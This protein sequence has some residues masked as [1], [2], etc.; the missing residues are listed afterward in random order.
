MKRALLLT[1]ILTAACGS[2]P[3]P[4]APEPK[5][6]ARVAAPELRPPRETEEE[7]ESGEDAAAVLRR[8]YE[9]IERG[10]YAAAWAMRGGEDDEAARRRFADNFRAY[11]RYHAEI[12]TPS[13]PASADGYQYVEVP[14]MIT[15]AFRGGKSFGSTGSVTLRRATSA[16]GSGW[17]IYTGGG[18]KAGR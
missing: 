17:R 1:S 7:R 3:A 14:V 4:Q 16:D 5:R 9:R 15:G 12:G 13:V 8:Y 18:R 2:D 6:F 10:D 11:E